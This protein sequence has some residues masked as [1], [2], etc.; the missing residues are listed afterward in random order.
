M[1]AGTHPPP[2]CNQAAL[3]QSAF[4]YPDRWRQLGLTHPSIP[5]EINAAPSS[6]MSVTCGFSTRDRSLLYGT[7]HSSLFQVFR[8][9]YRGNDFPILLG[10][11]CLPLSYLYKTKLPTALGIEPGSICKVNFTDVD[12]NHLTTLTSAIVAFWYSKKSM[13]I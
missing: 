7:F 2:P 6:S 3:L 11:T 5:Y 1:L 10:Y 9:S 12:Y 13:K 4:N 8:P